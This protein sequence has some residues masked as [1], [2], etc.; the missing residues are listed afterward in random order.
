MW[1]YHKMHFVAG[2][3]LLTSMY[4]LWMQSTSPSSSPEQYLE[5]RRGSVNTMEWM[6]L[7]WPGKR[8]KSLYNPM[9]FALSFR[10]PR[11]PAKSGAARCPFCS[12]PRCS[13]FVAWLASG[14]TSL[15]LS[16]KAVHVCAHASVHTQRSYSRGM[17]G[18]HAPGK[19]FTCSMWWHNLQT[20]QTR[21]TWQGS[22]FSKSNWIKSVCA[23]YIL[24]IFSFFPE[25]YSLL[26]SLHILSSITWNWQF[27]FPEGYWNHLFLSVF[28]Q[29][30]LIGAD[31]NWSLTMGLVLS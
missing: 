1:M 13:A 23:V 17:R 3:A 2:W 6:A 14:S 9:P 7:F 26:F 27:S 10:S 29:A 20:P 5:Q 21:G 8:C 24:R 12:T 30:Q 11:D 16:R 25:S 31:V 22:E 19:R 28:S 18:T 15:C 4:A